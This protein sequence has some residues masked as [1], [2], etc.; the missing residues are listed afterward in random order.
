MCQSLV[1]NIESN[2]NDDISEIIKDAD[3]ECDVVTKNNILLDPM[4]KTLVKREINYIILLLKN[5]ETPN[6]ICQGLQF[7]PLSK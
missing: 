3:K 5:R 1:K 6:Q 2:L 7:C 4:C